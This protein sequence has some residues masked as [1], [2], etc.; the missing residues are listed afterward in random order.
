MNFDP[1]APDRGATAG[2]RRDL[3]AV[4]AAALQRVDGRVA[5]RRQLAGLR[6]HFILL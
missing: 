4:Y 2:L 6:L 3:L 1:F 5:V